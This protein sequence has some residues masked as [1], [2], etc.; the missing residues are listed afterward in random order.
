MDI[1]YRELREGEI[2]RELFR[3]FKRYQKV[4]ICLRRDGDGWVE[5]PDPFIDDWGEKEY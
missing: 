3:H 4:D 5:K 1:S 2:D